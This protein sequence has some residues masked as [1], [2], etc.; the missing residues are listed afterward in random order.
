MEWWPLIRQNIG[1]QPF[2]VRIRTYHVSDANAGFPAAH[3]V[4]NGAEKLV[5]LHLDDGPWL[6][7]GHSQ[8]QHSSHQQNRLSKSNASKKGTMH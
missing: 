6:L 7:N 3:D 1:T 5:G 8:Q 2:D 4:L